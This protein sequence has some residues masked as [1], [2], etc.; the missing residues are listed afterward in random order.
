MNVGYRCDNLM[1]YIYI[2]C[3]D[4]FFFDNPAYFQK[5][6]GKEEGKTFTGAVGGRDL[7]NFSLAATS[8]SSPPFLII[9]SLPAPVIQCPGGLLIPSPSALAL[10]STLLLFISLTLSPRYSTFFSC[11]KTNKLDFFKWQS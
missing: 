6:G 1:L 3:L 2:L 9:S 7:R 5:K 10:C 4:T 11:N 8:S